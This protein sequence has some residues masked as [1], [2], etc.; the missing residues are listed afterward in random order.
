MQLPAPQITLDN[1]VRIQTLPGPSPATAVIA[2]HVRSGFR[3]EPEGLPGL[4]HLFEH[5]LFE[6]A[7]GTADDSFL[8]T[9]SKIGGYAAA[10]TRHNYTEFFDV[11]PRSHLYDVLTLEGNRFLADP[12]G[13]DAIHNQLKIINAEILEVTRSTPTGGF[14]WMQLPEVMYTH[15]ENT[16]DGYGDV[17]ALARAS[18]DD[19][20]E[21]FYHAYAPANLIVTVAADDLTEAEKNTLT[22][23]F[24]A[25]QERTAHTPVFRKEPQATAD[26]HSDSVHPICPQSTTSVGV[27]LPDPIKEPQLYRGST[28]LGTLIS[29]LSGPGGPRPQTGWFSRPLDTGTPD[30]WIVTAPAHGD[31]PGANLTEIIRT[32]LTPWAAGDITDE[33]LTLLTAQL[34]IDSQ[35]RAQAP[36]FTARTAG[37]RSL[38][39]T[40]PENVFEA[41]CYYRGVH[42]NDLVAAAKW[43]LNQPVASVTIRKENP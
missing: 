11:I 17:N 35:R 40:A 37:A 2:V 26:R 42:R 41:D 28:A 29:I 23:H 16:H 19:I 15:W 39:Y 36:H 14:P 1:G 10:H 32:I 7:S 43:L 20:Q 24:G 31:T 4:A 25:I 3:T 5:M 34:R 33:Q 38:L 8:A 9:L 30:A 6:R 18:I 22:Q 13:A 12:P 27:T 21:R